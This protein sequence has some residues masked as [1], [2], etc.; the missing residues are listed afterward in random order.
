MAKT[1]A[2]LLIKVKQTGQKV[3]KSIPAALKSIGTAALRAG[4]ALGTLT[5]GALALAKTGAEFDAVKNS[6]KNLAEQQGQDANKMLGKM[7][8]LS[9]GTVD[10]LT[11]MKQANNALLLGL[12]VDRFGDMLNIARSASKA[13]GESMEFMLKSITTGLGRQS[14]LVLDNLGIVFNLEDAYKDYARTIGTTA[15]KLTDDQKKQAFL[16]KALE[17]GTENAKKAGGGQI[18]LSDRIQAMIARLKNL[19]VVIGKNVGPM[20]VFFINKVEQ[21]AKSVE[22]W[23]TSSQALDFFK[24]L[25]KV[26]NFAKLSFEAYGATVGI[27]LAAIFESGSALLSGQFSQAKDILALGMDEIHNTLRAK[28]EEFDADNAELDALFLEREKQK[29]VEE[30][31]AKI[32][33]QAMLAAADE[34]SKKDLE[35]TEKQKHEVKQTWA[36]KTLKLEQLTGKQ[37][38][39]FQ[40]DTFATIATMQSSSNKT[41]ANIGKA[42]AL[43]QIA[44]AAPQGVAKALAAFPPPYNFAAAAAVGASFAV[45]AAQVAGIKLAD[46]G[47]VPASQGGT[48][49]TIGE[50]GRDEAV[51]PLDDE[52]SPL[53]G[54][55]T[56][57]V[58]GGLLGDESSARELAAAL[59]REMFKLRQNNESLAF[60]SG[61]I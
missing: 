19:S 49:A 54:N 36:L 35:K 42:A 30:L 34:K 25:S 22:K 28:R 33:H 53:G 6:F 11:L 10:D 18:D 27:G 39:Q 20:M 58:N 51:I 32:Q 21:T 38:E 5:A 7:R 1:E 45:Q 24:G 48:Q 26:V 14:K 16:N 4:V 59:D 8:E 13:T 56:I 29:K 50:G 15:S 55:I 40:A 60:D 3:L 2:T 41:L 47:I 43:T 61:V 46:G 23:V 44:I 57:I 12:P 52:S 37:K 9:A 31:D 17:I